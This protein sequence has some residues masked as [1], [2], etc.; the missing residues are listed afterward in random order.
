MRVAYVVSR[1]LPS[2]GGVETHVAQIA[3]RVAARGH[4][5]D[6]LT[7]EGDSSLPAVEIIDGV[8]VRRFPLVLPDPVYPFSASLWRYLARHRTNYDLVHAHNYHAF[9]SLGAALLGP[10]PLVFTPHYHGTGHRPL[11]RLLHLPYRVAGAL[12]FKRS[13]AVICVSQFEATLVRRHFPFVSARVSVIPNGVDVA[14]INA[15][16]PYPQD[17]AVIL[18]VGRLLGYKNV[19]RTVEALAHLDES[20][21]L[22][23]IGDG[24]ARPSLEALAHRL[25]LDGRVRFLGRVDE[26]ELYRWYRTAAVYVSMSGEEAFG[27]TLLEA[28]AG[29]ARVVAADIP[30]HREVLSGIDGGRVVLVPQRLEPEALA[31]TIRQLAAVPAHRTP[32][33]GVPS[34]DD[35]VERTLQLYQRVLAAA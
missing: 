2:T 24:P 10:R 5:V 11:G 32:V 27:L 19:Q 35:I 9:P 3:S 14:A 15:A 7:Q 29:G 1:Y 28:L 18:S 26:S 20:F 6:V 12:M 34:W 8:T 33:S 16:E 23:V 17:R 30:A 31:S 25:Q 4:Q 21:S 22:Q 13:S